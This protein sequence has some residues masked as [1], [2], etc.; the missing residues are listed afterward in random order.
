MTSS[1]P[2]A[3]EAMLPEDFGAG[4]LR[5]DLGAGVVAGFTTRH[6]GVSPAPWSSLDLSDGT[7][8]DSARVQR[9]RDL[10]ADWVGSPVAFAT[11]V[12]G[13]DVLELGPH[14]RAEWSGTPPT[15]AGTA[16]GLVTAEPGLGLG[17]LVADCVPVLLADATARVVGVAHAGRRGLVAGVV[18]EVVDRLLTRGAETGRLRAAVGPAVCGRCYE[19]PEQMRDEVTAVVP[20]AWS[21]TSAGT[22]G[23]DLP[24]A[25]VTRLVARGVATTRVDRCTMTDP[26]LFSHRRATAA[27]EVTGRQ[28]GVV[29]LS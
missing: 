26:D 4:L 19:V 22:P 11:Q 12:H 25:V 17:V 6:G 9:N 21:T 1:V 13:A 10:L 2:W 20:E 23:L 8:D 5:V 27:G 15:S 14:E 7:G 24:G 29:V 18:D 16:D 28:A 3:Q